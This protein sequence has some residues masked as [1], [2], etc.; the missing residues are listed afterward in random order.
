MKISHFPW[1]VLVRSGTKCDERTN[2][3]MQCTTESL[4]HSSQ[5]LSNF[6]LRVRFRP[7]TRTAYYNLLS[8]LFASGSTRKALRPTYIVPILTQ[9]PAKQEVYGDKDDWNPSMATGV[10]LMLLANCTCN[11]VQLQVRKL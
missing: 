4:V 11:D 7:G 2:T 3:L 9:S 5:A 10:C 6:V 8:T 1:F